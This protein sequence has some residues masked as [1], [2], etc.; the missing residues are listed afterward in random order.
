MANFRNMLKIMKEND[1]PVI[2]WIEIEKSI[3]TGYIEDVG[4]DCLVMT[5]EKGKY[6]AVIPLD[7]IMMVEVAPDLA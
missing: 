1:E 4:E 7:K 2:V 3:F 5:F 6:N